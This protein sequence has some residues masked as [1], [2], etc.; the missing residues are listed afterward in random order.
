MRS[1]T[2]KARREHWFLREALEKRFADCGLTLHPEKTKIVS[3]KDDRRS[4][5]HPDQSFDFLSYTFRPR[6]VKWPDGTIGVGFNPAI[7]NK[8][9]RK[10]VRLCEAGLFIG[11]PIGLWNIWPSDQSGDTRMDQLLWPVPE[12]GSG[13]SPWA[14]QCPLGVVGLSEVQVLAPQ[15][16]T[17]TPLAGSP[18]RRQPGLLRTG[19]WW[20][21]RA[22][23]GSR[24]RREFHVRFC[25]RAG[26]RVPRATLLPSCRRHCA[27]RHDNCLRR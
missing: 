3:C 10:S 13:S 6:S 12:V 19:G 9:L 5:N 4:G 14:H 15:S 17:G 23:N 20:G 2:V 24:M 1:V 16:G 18:G 21:Q 7:S 25:E 27:G 26:V 8:A 22:D 11:A